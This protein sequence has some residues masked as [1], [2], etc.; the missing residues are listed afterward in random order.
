MH[1]DCRHV[2]AQLS[3][4]TRLTTLVLNTSGTEDTQLTIPADALPC[5][6]QRL[7]LTQD[8]DNYTINSLDHTTLPSLLR[9]FA[10]LDSLRQ[11]HL[12]VDTCEKHSLPIG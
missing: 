12:T 5:S 7:R 8:I 1:D 3:A 2:P 9:D 11:L 6:L 4:A 10:S